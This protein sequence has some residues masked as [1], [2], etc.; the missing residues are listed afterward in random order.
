MVYELRDLM[1]GAYPELIDN[2]SRVIQV[3]EAEERQFARVL[4]LGSKE[5]EA[6]IEKVKGGWF[7]RSNFDAFEIQQFGQLREPRPNEN[8]AQLSG[9]RAFHLYETFGLPLD[10][11]VEAA[12]DAGVQFDYE[13]FE[14]A[15]EAEQARARA[16][17]KGGTQKTA[18]PAFRDLPKTLFEGYKQLTST[19]CEVLASSRT[20]RVFP[21][22]LLAMKLKSSST[23]RASTLTPVAKSATRAGSSLST[24]TPLSPRSW[25]ALCLC[26]ACAHTKLY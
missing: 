20:A 9:D 1:G 5:L 26:K 15:K 7:Q 11:M 14:A 4:E 24:A 25:A 12:R 13:G 19:N 17:W 3:V 6:E 16:S 10:F 22:P 8:P 18:S 21:P 23:I 2:A